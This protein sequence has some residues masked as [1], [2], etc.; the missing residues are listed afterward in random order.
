MQHGKEEVASAGWIISVGGKLND[1]LFS[2]HRRDDDSSYLQATSVGR[3][4]RLTD[5]TF[6]NRVVA[7]TAKA[8]VQ[9]AVEIRSR[10]FSWRKLLKFLSGRQEPDRGIYCVC[11]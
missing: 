4:L 3:G 1:E 11:D 2:L 10:L 6:W 8:N 9:L 7:A 5:A